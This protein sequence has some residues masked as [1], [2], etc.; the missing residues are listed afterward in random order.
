MANAYTDI[1]QMD[2]SAAAD[3]EA[4]YVLQGRDQIVTFHTCVG[5]D[6]VAL[7]FGTG[8][9]A[10]RSVVSTRMARKIWTLLVAGG[11]TRIA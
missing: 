4:C 11:H 8:P 9:W 3:R 5:E 7:S 2:E 10:T 1:L 6:S